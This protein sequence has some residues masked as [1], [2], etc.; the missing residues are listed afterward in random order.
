MFSAEEAEQGVF[1]I[2]AQAVAVRVSCLSGGQL[3]T[4]LTLHPTA[5]RTKWGFIELSLT[6]YR[7]E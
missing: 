2:G 4:I 3:T 7:V 1:K 5:Y 6:P